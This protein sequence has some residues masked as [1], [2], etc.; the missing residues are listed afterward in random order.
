[1]WSGI[2]SE[3]G[4]PLTSWRDVDRTS[5]AGMEPAA[6]RGVMTPGGWVLV[7]AL[8]PGT[9]F[10]SYQRDARPISTAESRLA[11]GAATPG[12]IGTSGTVEPE[13]FPQAV[14]REVETITGSLDGYELIGRRVDLHASVRDAASDVAFWMGDG[15]NRILVV[16]PDGHRQ[17]TA[18]QQQAA[19][20]GTVQ[21]VPKAETTLQ[22]RLTPTDAA[23]LSDRRIYI[24]AD[25]AASHRH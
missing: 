4:G 1:M 2:L 9:A 8:V 19:I 25:N 18:G 21:R 22:W 11:A 13:P 23:E 10:L 5:P 7:L 24:R 16:M 3:G 15:D 14:I 20:V 6:F 12:A 17:R